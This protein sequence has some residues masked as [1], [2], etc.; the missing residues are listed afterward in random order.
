[1]TRYQEIDALIVEL[2]AS[3]EASALTN[4]AARMI[5]ILHRELLSAERELES[6]YQDMAGES[7]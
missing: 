3:D 6:V 2:W 1:M 5:D 4:R 7:I